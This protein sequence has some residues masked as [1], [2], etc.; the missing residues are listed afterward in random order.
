VITPERGPA[1]LDAMAAEV[2]QLLASADRA[3]A[4]GYPGERPGRQP[5]HTAYL[6]A[7]RF[8]PGLA[9]RW[10]RQALA[11]LQDWAPG[12]ADFG[13]AM[14]LPAALAADVRSRVLAKLIAEPVEDLRLDFEDGYG[15]RGD[16]A[17]DGDA[18]RAAE[19]LAAE[20]AA[21]AAP[22]FTGLRCKSL[23]PATRRRALRTLDAFLAGLLA[24]GPLPDGFV[25]TLPKVT[26]ADQVTAMARV[27]GLLEQAHG[28][29][30]GALVFEVQ[31]ETP[32]VILGADGTAVIARC[33]HAAHEGRLTGLHYGTYDYSAALGIAAQQQSLE[34]PVA[35][36][37]RAV[38]QVAAAGTGV[39]LCDGSSN[40]L[41]E[42]GRDQVIEAWAR[43]ARL[44]R[45]S[46]DR[47]FYQGWDM[48][49][50]QLASRYAATFGFFREG[51]PAAAARL[52]GYVERRTGAGTDGAGSGTDGA[53]SGRDGAGTGRDGAGTDGAGSGTDGAGSG[54]DGAGSAAGQGERV[55]EEPATARALAGFLRR[56][57]DCG[58]VTEPELA[59]LT[60][61]DRAGLEALA[62]PLG[63]GG[64][65][66]PS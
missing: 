10:G 25:I 56:G 50:A 58:A 46:L 32:Q 2:D 62:V 1:A 16:D 6:P 20:V 41:P 37:A 60:G 7:D 43:H 66:W 38:M 30:P 21:G 5:V 63:A 53:G 57:L 61:L 44:V 18:R 65:R 33:V 39:R 22:P 35:D 31:V 4:R 17:E 45:R 12:P 19:C 14:G 52:R 47:G 8:G 26:S 51:L 48:H 40:V 9:A 29:T 55:L 59:G 34:H 49:P 23:E 11:A 64:R 36:H 28:L 15:D 42:G 27:C 54:T 13:R 3:L 24:R